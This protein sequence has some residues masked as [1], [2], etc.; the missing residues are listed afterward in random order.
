MNKKAALSF[1]LRPSLFLTLL[2]VLAHSLAVAGLLA[3]PWPMMLRIALAL[4]LLASAM[5]SIRRHGRLTDPLSIVQLMRR[6]DGLIL[7]QTQN[8]RIRPAQIQLDSAIFPWLIVVRLVLGGIE[9]DI[10]NPR[11]W[12]VLSQRLA[13]HRSLVILADTLEEEDRRQLRIWLKW[14]LAEEGG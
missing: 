7:C 12:T 9:E 1:R 5:F 4:L 13:R 6:S 8:G 10:A 3:L 11:P 14:Q 2:L